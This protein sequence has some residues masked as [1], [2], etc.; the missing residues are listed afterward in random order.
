MHHFDGQEKDKPKKEFYTSQTINAPL[1]SPDKQNQ[2]SNPKGDFQML[3]NNEI[4]TSDVRGSQQGRNFGSGQIPKRVNTFQDGSGKY[5]KQSNAFSKK[6]SINQGNS[7][8]IISDLGK[9]EQ[10]QPTDGKIGNSGQT[11][12]L[13]MISKFEGNGEE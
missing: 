2:Q 7:K 6:E 4:L 1:Q 9:V 8:F 5:I 3:G 12:E 13:G 11:I 10:F